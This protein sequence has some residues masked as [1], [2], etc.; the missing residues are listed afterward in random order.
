MNESVED[1]TGGLV[2]MKTAAFML[3]CGDWPLCRNQIELRCMYYRTV[4]MGASCSLGFCGFGVFCSIAAFLSMTREPKLKGGSSGVGRIIGI[5][6]FAS[7]RFVTALPRRVFALD[8]DSSK[9]L[10]LQTWPS[11]AACGPDV[12]AE[13]WHPVSESRIRWE[14]VS[15]PIWSA[16]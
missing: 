5:L 2:N 4:Q 1:K 8:A 9:K 16:L 3:D 11:F 15:Q 12:V 6:H 13:V 14:G 10:A 7:R